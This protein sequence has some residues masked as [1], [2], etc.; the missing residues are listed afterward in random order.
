MPLHLTFSW[1]FLPTTKPHSLPT[2]LTQGK[3]RSSLPRMQNN[4]LHTYTSPTLP[5]FPGT[6]RRRRGL[7]SATRT[8]TYRFNHVLFSGR[9]PMTPLKSRSWLYDV[10]I[11]RIKLASLISFCLSALANTLVLLKIKICTSKKQ[12]EVRWK[13]KLPGFTGRYCLF[14]WL[15]RSLQ[16]LFVASNQPLGK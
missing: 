4:S 15:H 1:P 6:K 9:V 16:F 3:G 10:A 7:V 11:H 5:L 12:M 2:S 8:Y 13:P 14:N